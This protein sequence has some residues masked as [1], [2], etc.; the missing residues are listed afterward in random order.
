MSESA[1]AYPMIDETILDELVPPPGPLWRRVAL[2]VAFLGIVGATAWATAS[3]TVIP[4]IS[5]S[6][7]GWGDDGPIMVATSVQN[8]SRVDIEVVDGPRPRPGLSLLGYT[9]GSVTPVDTMPEEKLADPF[10]LR[11]KPDEFVDLTAW[12]RVTDCQ[13]I[14]DINQNDDQIDLQVRIADGPA[15]WFTAERNIDAQDL[16]SFDSA[17]TSWPAA[18]AH[19][20]CNK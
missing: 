12:Y 9:T 15:S 10:P 20:A 18:I 6:A 17:Q 1:T 2:W 13:A 16:G 7:N 19:Q 5:T 4:Q 8:T 3:G 14:E 11:L